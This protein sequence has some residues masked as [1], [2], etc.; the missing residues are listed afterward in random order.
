MKRVIIAYLMLCL[1][2][3]IAINAEKEP[4]GN[5]LY[6]E[7][8]DNG[9]LTIS[10]NGEMPNFNYISGEG[11]RIFK[12]PWYNERKKIRRVVL[13]YGVTS[14]GDYAFYTRP[15]DWRSKY[16]ISIIEIPNS[17][18]SIGKRAF[19]NLEQL[20]SVTIPNSVISIGHNAFAGCTN[21]SSVSLSNSLEE[22]PEE[23][24]SVCENLSSIEIPNSVTSIGKGA[25]HFC[26]FTSIVIPASVKSIGKS[27]FWQC[28]ELQSI[29]IHSS[30]I[31]IG[32]EAFGCCRG[33]TSVNIPKSVTAIG[34]KAFLGCPRLNSI[35]S[36]PDFIVNNPAKYGLS[37]E[38]VNAY[39]N[40]I[41]NKEGVVVL[42]VKEGRKIRKC[43]SEPNN[44]VYYLVEENGN[45]GIINENGI[46]TIPKERNYHK[47]TEI[48]GNYIKVSKDNSYGIFA[49]DGKEIIPTSRCYTYIG[50][51]DS[52][53]GTFAFTK[54]GFSGVCDAQ[55]REISTTK[56]APTADDIKTYGGYASTVEMKNGNTKYYKVSKSGRYGLTD[57]DGKEIIPCEMEALE[58]AGT[59]YLRYKING[60][61]GVMNY[62]G[63]ILIDTDR[64]YT[65]IGDFKTFNKRFPY[66]MA[67]YKGECD[68]NGKQILKIKVETPKQTVA[69]SSS[70]SNSS[71]SS[72]NN[73]S[74]SNSGSGTTQSVVVEHHRDPMPVQE[75]QQ[76]VACYGSGQC[77]NVSCGGSGWYYIGDRARTCS[78]CHGSGKCTICA[79]KGGQYVTVYR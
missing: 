74:S 28:K 68:I 77:P 16:A 2:V 64:G 8:S 7:L 65:S 42:S 56:L 35:I 38:A 52:N 61:W 19:D 3:P 9:T 47:F 79:G 63:K 26:K 67:G 48:G 29:T 4:F 59:G 25:F 1:V 70:S 37:N 10:G 23:C 62:T 44:V 15:K 36:L 21:L 45:E 20:R 34:E 6:W 22:I 39:K 12:A 50:D 71:F 14:I 53:K 73:S 58:S 55:G 27:A 41:R 57:S 32:E 31:S 69:S 78:R 17:V 51:Y 5:G 54:K 75:W 43:Q 18:K 24:F 40:S 33:L 49:L 11:Q 72:T 13:E 66:T 46:W 76:C 60:F 30:V